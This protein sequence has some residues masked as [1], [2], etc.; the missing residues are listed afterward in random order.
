MH[1]DR[2]R[3]DFAE[4]QCGARPRERAAVYAVTG[5][6]PGIQIHGRRIPVRL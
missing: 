6:V 1:A 3:N 4:N 5:T 2:E